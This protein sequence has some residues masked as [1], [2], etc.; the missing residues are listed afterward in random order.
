METISDSVLKD[1]AKKLRTKVYGQITHI[2]DEDNRE[3]LILTKSIYD[4]Y[5]S[6]L[7]NTFQFNNYSEQ[8]RIAMIKRICEIF[9]LEFDKENQSNSLLIK[10]EPF[11]ITNKIVGVK[12][13][14]SIINIIE[15]ELLNRIK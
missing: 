5:I 11:G 15:K 10:Q 4:R 12:D 2:V 3:A 9:R 7:D 6:E 13:S 14:N 8:H 1:S